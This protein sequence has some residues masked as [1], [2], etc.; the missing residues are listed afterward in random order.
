MDPR[1]AK[2]RLHLQEAL[3]E[4]VAERGIDDVAVSD[5]A[6][7]AGVNR[8]TFYLHYSDKE[9]LLADALDLVAQR[10]GADLDHIDVASAEPPEAL[11]DFL[12]HV[13]DLADL[14]RRIF[15]EPGYGVA[16]A[17]LR[18]HM[19]QAI[20]RLADASPTD[21]APDAPAGFVAAGVAG[22]ILGMV[23]AWLE[24]EPLAS[25]REVARWAWAVVP[26]PTGARD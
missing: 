7:R 17:R 10:A 25:P 9:T 1:T 21:R 20:E 8:T 11:V 4:L 3:F 14:Y 18:V 26:L 24:S 5:I 19:I 15:T 23:G 22:S 2:T 12:A 6:Q 13:Y 16:L